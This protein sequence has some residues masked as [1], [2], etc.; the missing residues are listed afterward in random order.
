MRPAYLARRLFQFLVVLWGAATLNFLLPRLA[1]GNPVRER[2]TNAMAQ[3]GLLQSGIEEMVQAYNKEFGLDQPLYLQY[4][5]YIAHAFRLDFGYSIAQYPRRVAPMI[6][7][8]LPWTIGL[9]V[10]ATVVAFVLG[11]FVGALMAWPRAPRWIAYLAGPSI[12]VS[13]IPYFLLGMVLVYA[14]GVV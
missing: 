14:L 3:G 12:V 11:T 2:L 10:S 9:L 6:W 7:E 13:S 1:P 8:A 5:N 4:L